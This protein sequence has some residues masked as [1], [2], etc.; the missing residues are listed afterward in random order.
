[1][2]NIIPATA[3]DDGK[4]QII[5]GHLAEGENH[6]YMLLYLKQEDNLSIYVEALSGN[7]DPAIALA[8]SSS[9]PGELR[10]SFYDDIDAKIEEGHHPLVVLPELQDKYLLAWDNDS[11]EGY[12]AAQTFQISAFSTF[13]IRAL[14]IVFNLILKRLEM[15][16]RED[17][18]QRI[19]K[20]SVWLYPLIYFVTFGIIA[21]I[22]F[23]YNFF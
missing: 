1:M 14:V 21:I 13:I 17:T 9:D 12:N 22:F 18:A 4:V 5:E 6:L 8:D 3:H 19:D 7:L 23:G 15:P 10:E 16:D 11:G 2:I 20:F